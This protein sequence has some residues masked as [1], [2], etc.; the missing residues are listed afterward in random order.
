MQMEIEILHGAIATLIGM[1]PVKE[2]I[3]APDLDS[4]K[5]YNRKFPNN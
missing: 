3:K 2:N 4:G 1:D 5:W